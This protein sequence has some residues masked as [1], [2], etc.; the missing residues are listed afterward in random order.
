M[1]KLSPLV[2]T[3]LFVRDLERSA[4][5]YREVLELTEPYY[6]GTLDDPTACSC[7][8]YRRARWPAR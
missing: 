2:R 7:W 5:F 4:A 6:E 8:A 3:A 1:I